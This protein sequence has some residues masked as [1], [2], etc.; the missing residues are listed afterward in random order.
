[1]HN[2]L[3]PDLGGK[4]VKTI[5]L[6]INGRDVIV[7]RGGTV[8]QAIQEAG[9]YVPTLC[10]DPDLKPYGACRLCIV[11]IEGMRGLPTSCTTPAEEGMV[12]YTETEE[13]ERIRRTIVEMAIAD[14]PYDCL[15][16]DNSGECD[17][18]KVARYVSVDRNSVARQRRKTTAR[19]V[20]TS[21]PAFDLDQN[22]CILCGKCVR[23]CNEIVGLGAI[24]F[25]FRGYNT[26]V[27]PFGLKPMAQS[28]CQSCG[29][30]VERC[31]VGA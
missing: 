7:P 13:I 8:L 4:P 5:K 22:K 27:G 25:A 29:E 23:T 6:T 21:N 15:I 10:Y 20:D 31:P 26:R 2:T 24:D 18:L 9:I 17:L 14:H 19:P 28:I 1:M 3:D 30:C 11:Q 16:C 12:V